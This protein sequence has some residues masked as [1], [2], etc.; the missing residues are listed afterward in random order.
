MPALRLCPLT[1]VLADTHLVL[2]GPGVVGVQRG[3]SGGGVKC[4]VELEEEET[5][6]QVTREERRPM[7][8]DCARSG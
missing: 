7:S 4:A 8:L 3:L 2:W 5:P 6:Q 1:A